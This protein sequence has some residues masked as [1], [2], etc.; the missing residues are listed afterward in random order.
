MF[1]RLIILIAG[2]DDYNST[3]VIDID[4]PDC[5]LALLFSHCVFSFLFRCEDAIGISSAGFAG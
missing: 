1:I 3:Y 2:Q 4:D 5:F